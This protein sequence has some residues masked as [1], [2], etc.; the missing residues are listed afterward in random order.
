LPQKTRRWTGNGKKR[1][2]TKPE[3]WL[4]PAS[5][6]SGEGLGVITWGV[7]AFTGERR[8][9]PTRKG[10]GILEKGGGNSPY[11]GNEQQSKLSDIML[12]SLNKKVRK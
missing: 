10:V 9:R 11:K 6:T 1:W 12:G 5:M 3:G 2:G 4:D 7:D 8:T